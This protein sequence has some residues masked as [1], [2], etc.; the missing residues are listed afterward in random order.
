MP[1]EAD[2]GPGPVRRILRQP[3]E[4][5]ANANLRCNDQLLL[6][7]FDRLHLPAHL[8]DKDIKDLSGGEKQ[9]VAIVSA[10]LLN[11][12]IVLLDEAASALDRENAL[13]VADYFREQ[14]D[15]TIV[16]AAHNAQI[17]PLS[18]HVVSLARRQDLMTAV[19]IDLRGMLIGYLLLIFPL[20]II[21][22]LRVPLLKDTTVAVLRM[23]LQLLFVGFYLQVIFQLNSAW[24]NALWLLAMIV[25]ADISI[26]RSCRLRLSRFGPPLF[27]AL[28]LGTF[29]PL[30]LIV[31]PILQRPQILDAQYAIPL[32]GMILGNCLRADIMGIRDFYE[33]IRKGE[34]TFL[35]SLAQGASLAEATRPHFRDACMQR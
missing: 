8:L 22:W 31:V 27:L 1:Q 23:T 33:S 10:I 16:S 2:L 34:K 18:E 9:R 26:L 5:R 14:R 28:L 20:A 29:A 13:A 4:Y 12:S 21:L 30:L 3:F 32:G 11:R 7:I 6:D 15:L 19:D 24:L 25:V 17:L 35:L